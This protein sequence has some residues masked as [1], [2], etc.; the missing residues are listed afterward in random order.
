MIRK[1]TADDLDI[2]NEYLYRN[3][4]LNLFLISDIE[5]FGLQNDN[6]EVFIDITSNIQGVYL[7]FFNNMCL[8]SY[9]NTI[10]IEFVKSIVEK[11]KIEN[12]NGATD[13]INS[14]NLDGFCVKDFNLATLNKLDVEIESDGVSELNI[15][16]FQE[17][18]E[19]SNKVF[20][21]TSDEK[22]AKAEFET[23]SRHMV[24]YKVD[25]E[26]VSG[27]SSCAESKELAML[28]TVFTDENHRRKG[29]AIK[30][31]A[32]ICKKLIAEGKTVCLFYDNPNAA[33]MYKRLGF[34]DIGYLSTSSRIK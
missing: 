31:V 29:L 33:K 25:G 32:N 18:L 21:N 15:D 30:C 16:N 1:C 10:D 26:I 34:K 8:A 9:N 24:V 7:R 4:E 2:L 14:L 22:S 11:H 13:L 6:V 3:K 12:I 5:V 19:K 20:N 27:A 17:S 23:N 28:V